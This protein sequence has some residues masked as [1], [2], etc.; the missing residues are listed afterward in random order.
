MSQVMQALNSSQQGYQE[1][2]IPSQYVTSKV[3]EEKSRF[4]WYHSIL[5]LAPA[6]IV[7]GG[8]TYHSIESQKQ[9]IA[10][11]LAMPVAVETVSAS[12]D[13]LEYPQ[14]SELK[15]TYVE[16]KLKSE[17]ELGEQITVVN[18]TS[19]VEQEITVAKQTVDQD[20]AAVNLHQ[21]DLSELSPALAMRVESA[22]KGSTTANSAQVIPSNTVSLIQRADQFSGRLPAMDFQ[23][24]VYASD[25]KKRWIK[26][27]GIEY[28]EGDWMPDG[29]ELQ[30]I[31]PRTVIV[32]FDN[33][34][35]EI[36][37]LH[38]WKG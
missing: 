22:L 4:R 13:Y 15:S 33:Q 16:P 9:K 2:A 8:L 25:V 35:I 14:F 36:P 20:G 26:M 18:S 37:A 19:E 7:C 11:L 5:L 12:F 34:S 38:T 28:Q 1:N 32:K 10:N 31:T 21:L 29:V 17:Q 27:N 30:A 6:A 24:H 3:S 23:T